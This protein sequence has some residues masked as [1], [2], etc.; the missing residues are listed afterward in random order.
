MGAGAIPGPGARTVENKGGITGAGA[1]PDPGARTKEVTESVGAVPSSGVR[2]G[3]SCHAIMVSDETV[4][5]E[6]EMTGEKCH[7]KCWLEML[8]STLV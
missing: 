8:V 1:I 3:W 4:S 2:G 6:T 7:L 5:W